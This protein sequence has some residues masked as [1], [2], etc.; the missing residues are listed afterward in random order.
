MEHVWLRLCKCSACALERL[1]IGNMPGYLLGMSLNA[2]MLTNSF[3]G[4][5]FFSLK[6]LFYH[7]YEFC[8]EAKSPLS[9]LI[10][11]FKNIEFLLS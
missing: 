3:E 7:F 8:P 9:M 1:G 5:I 2:I 6:Y 11:I 10:E 4:T